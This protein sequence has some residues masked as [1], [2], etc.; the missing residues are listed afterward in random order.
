MKRG[1]KADL[2][3]VNRG[4]LE[5]VLLVILFAL[6]L[7]PGYAADSSVVGQKISA[8]SPS[9]ISGRVLGDPSKIVFPSLKLDCGYVGFLRH[10]RIIIESRFF[11]PR[12]VDLSGS[13]WPLNFEIP[14]VMRRGSFGLAGYVAPLAAWFGAIGA[15]NRGGRAYCCIW[16][17]A[18]RKPVFVWDDAGSIG[19]PI[20]IS[21]AG[22]LVAY[23]GKGGVIVRSFRGGVPRLFLFPKNHGSSI[24]VHYSLVFD[25]NGK[26]LFAATNNQIL[27]WDVPKGKILWRVN[28]PKL[29]ATYSGLAYLPSR[30]G[31]PLVACGAVSHKPKGP[32]D[33]LVDGVLLLNTVTGSLV[34]QISIPGSTPRAM[35]HPARMFLLGTLTAAPDG[36]ALAVTQTVGLG[37]GR[38]FIMGGRKWHIVYRTGWIP[39]GPWLGLA[40]SRKGG[41]IAGSGIGRVWVWRLRRRY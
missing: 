33:I 7:F 2:K 18:D 1:Q 3:I 5:C 11:G 36:R 35:A 25:G 38:V 28:A 16:D 19:A 37:Y 14:K 8:Q 21:E 31:T 29:L 23:G 12:L 24:P 39:G 6:P 32:R 20:T 26:R 17:A 22:F 40:F 34:H 10:R 9:K 41:T 30:N 15:Q 13:G 4:I 27:C